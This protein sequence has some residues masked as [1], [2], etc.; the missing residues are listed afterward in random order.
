MTKFTIEYNP[1]LTENM[2]I[3]KKNGKVL[4]ENSI[5]GSKS[6][7]RLQMIL[8]KSR[9]ELENWE[10]LPEQIAISCDDDEVEVYFK[11]RKMDFDDLKYTFDSY[12][13]SVK[14]NLVFEETK[15]D[16]DIIKE[17]DR[18]FNEIKKKNLPEFKVK[19]KD[20]KDIF[21]A[22]EEVKNGI[23]EINVI[24]TMSSGKSTL[25]NAL[26]HTELLPS[27]NKAC[28]ATVCSILDN[29]DMQEY[30][31][32]CYGS[33]HELVV[34]PRSVV[35]L[36]K[37]R[38]YNEDQQVNYI[39]IEGSIPAIPSD[40]IR[41]CL[42]DTPG[43]NNSRN[44]NHEK[45]TRS[46]IQRTNAVVLYI[47]NTTQMEVKSDKQL[48]QDIANE[49]KKA[50]KQS[51][52]RFIFVVNK[53]DEL[54][55]EKESLDDLLNQTRDYLKGFGIENPILIPTSARLAL[56]IR[57]R[58]N[59]EHLTR[60]ETETLGN[61]IDGFVEIDKLH[62]ENYANLTPTIQEKLKRKVDQYHENEDN[63]ELE[64][65]IHS[66]VP[67]VEETI[68]EYIEK[69]AYPMKI[70]D[71]MKD[72]VGILDHLDMK[73]KFEESIAKDD[74]KLEIV[75]G[76]IE[77]A[78]KKH[79]DSKEVYESF[80]K[81]VAAIDLGSISERNELKKVEKELQ[82]MSKDYDGKVKVDKIEA[83]NLIKT[84]EGNLDRFQKDCEARLNRT[85]DTLIFDKCENMLAEYTRI[86]K[87]IIADIE[88]E[89][90]DFRKISSFNR[91][92]IS[93]INEIKK[94][95][96]HDRYRKETRW[97]KNPERM[98][99]FGFFKFWKPR[100]ISYEVSVKDGVDVNVKKVIVDVL[101]EFSAS[102]KDNISNMFSEAE[103]QIEEYKETF[104]ENIDALNEEIGK[105]LKQLDSDTKEKNAIEQRVNK[106]KD[107][108]KW[109]DK[110]ESE[111]KTL[112]T[113]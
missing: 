87:T 33:N 89:G 82:S 108:A 93:N 29:D 27:E 66:G 23:F 92:K 20:G 7:V 73:T 111:I 95:N 106:N 36:D 90:Y 68:S 21:D 53:C 84:F 19:N 28:T 50:G 102:I 11:G 113:F 98:G 15:N 6:N 105:I 52:D 8:G 51:R 14:F 55:E 71:A 97:E 2:C 99:F 25:I 18:I 88:I 74:K 110:K 86:I 103:M 22:Y 41:L 26:L 32:T 49:M 30:E 96:E 79:D 60:K 100:E 64:A 70:N 43:P 56:L 35:T 45:L 72:I 3:F 47:M 59:G 85:I 39:D 31:A 58:I 75:R 62:Y 16:A 101:S 4:N 40:K 63:R 112:L 65:I 9:L 54:D 61:T 44:E 34:H 67:A 24:A 46:I 80:K 107:M 83:D 81:K 37:M 10:G 91:I 77:E 48:L 1:Y 104:N 94:R 12:Q 78:L 5:I 109:V 57:K 76:Q 17:L 69:Y 38:N 13:G 42:K